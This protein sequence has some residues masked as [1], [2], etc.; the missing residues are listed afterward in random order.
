MLP[1]LCQSP[2]SRSKLTALP[3]RDPL[4]TA[5]VPMRAEEEPLGVTQVSV[6]PSRSRRMSWPAW[7][8][9]RVVPVNE[10][11]TEPDARFETE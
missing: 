3:E 10:Q 1:L 5:P 2:V 6:P 8:M 9:L 7:V 11:V 4:T